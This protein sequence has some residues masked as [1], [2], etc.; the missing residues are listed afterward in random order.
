MTEHRTRSS[1]SGSENVSRPSLVEQSSAARQAAQLKAARSVSAGRPS[2]A[3]EDEDAPELLLARAIKTDVARDKRALAE[4]GL[5]LN[6]EGDEELECLLL[7][8]VYLAALEEERFEE[9]LDLADRMIELGELG[10][11]A[12]QDAARACLALGDVDAAVGHLRIAGR[13]SP[14]SRRAFHDWT[15]GTVLYLDG[16][17]AD[18]ILALS[19]A[20]RWATTQKPLYEALLA[21]ARHASGQ[22]VPDLAELRSQLEDSSCVM[23]YGELVLGELCAHLGDH[24]AAQRHLRSFVER[25]A[26]SRRAKTLT[27]TAELKHATRLL[28][29]LG[30]NL[31]PQ[32]A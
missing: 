5:R 4:R 22:A 26:Q 11:V 13:V 14:P 31:P 20:A 23:G 15:L 29:R 25:V 18:A 3:S 9:A 30:S 7:R 21:L 32:N 1:K 8:Q 12:R 16:R 27:L 19:R 2:P 28:Q 17:P 6:A 10:D 24:Q